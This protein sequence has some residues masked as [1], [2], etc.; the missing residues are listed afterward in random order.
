M[1]VPAEFYSSSFAGVEFMAGK[2]RRHKVEWDFA[3][4]LMPSVPPDPPTVYRDWMG[5]KPDTMSLPILIE[6]EQLRQDLADVS[7]YPGGTLTTPQG[8]WEATLDS[9]D[10]DGF[11]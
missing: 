8:S 10:S 4:S 2:G 6:N 9:L 11:R 5:R 7:G 1:P 3:D